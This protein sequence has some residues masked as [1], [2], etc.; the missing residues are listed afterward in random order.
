MGLLENSEALRNAVIE[1]LTNRLPNIDQVVLKQIF[2]LL[3]D[4]DSSGGYF[5]KT[6]P[7]VTKLI[8]LQNAISEVLTKSGYFKAADIY[9]ADLPKITQNTVDLM[10]GLNNK[11]I[12]LSSLKGRERQYIE[13][14]T[15]S[16]KEAGISVNFIDPIVTA[17]NEAVTFGYSIQS[18]RDALEKTILDTG[19]GQKIA[20]GNSLR[21]YLTVTARDTVAQMQGA[22]QQDI[23]AAFGMKWIR[24]IGGEVKDS[25]GQCVKWRNMAYLHIDELEELIAEAN[26]K[27]AA[28]VEY[29][30]G[31]KWSGMMPN[32]N[33]QN[34]CKNRGGYGCLHIAMPVLKKP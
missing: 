5:D 14:V 25:R 1:Q 10:K 27:Q 2:Q 32:T 11:D 28:K 12:S 18:T 24:Y 26:K 6:K 7:S 29:P 23:Q 34:F 21:K 33:T 13:Q 31:H 30:K 9:I 3:D 16:I 17:V 8:R 4:F 15:T 22:Q 20:G 19:N